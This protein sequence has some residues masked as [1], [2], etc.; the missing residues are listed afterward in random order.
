MKRLVI[1]M[2]LLAFVLAVPFA[3]AKEEAKKAEPKINCCEKGKCKQ[4]TEV[5]CKKAEG[6]VVA[7][8]KDCKV[9]CCVKGECQEMTK[10]ECSA[11]KG[12]V[13]SDCKKCKPPKAPKSKP[14][15]KPE[16]GPE[17]K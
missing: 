14:E 12:R 1:L 11:A 6:K 7:D 13:V 3:V 9:S 4:T 2:T 8:C 10:A 16:A 17:T 5:K 15:A